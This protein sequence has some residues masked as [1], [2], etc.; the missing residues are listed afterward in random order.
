MISQLRQS[1]AELT[2]KLEDK[3]M[4]LKG[5]NLGMPGLD[6]FLLFQYSTVETPVIFNK[7]RTNGTQGPESGYARPRLLCSLSV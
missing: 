4:E 5:L 2:R 1:N 3:T 7:P 6:S